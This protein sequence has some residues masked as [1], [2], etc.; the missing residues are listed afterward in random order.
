VSRRRPG[1]PWSALSDDS[2]LGDW[3]ARRRRGA[4]DSA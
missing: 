1:S 3:T 4:P 2:T